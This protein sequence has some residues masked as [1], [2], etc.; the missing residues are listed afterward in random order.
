MATYTGT[1]GNDSWTVVNPGTFSL[2]GLGGVDV[3]NLGTSLRS[4]YTITKASDG[5]VHIDSISSASGALHATL[6]NM[7]TLTFN[8][9]RDV[10]DLTTYFGDSIPPVLNSVSPLA[11]SSTVA[12]DA[13]LVFTFSEAIARG[14]GTVTLAKAD[15][16]VVATYNAADS[17]NL[18]IAGTALTINPTAD[19]DFGSSYKV[20]I[21]AGSIKD[22]AGNNYA[23]ESTYAFTTANGLVIAGTAGDDVLLGSKGSDTINAGAGNDSITGGPG[24]D[25]ID[26]GSG[27]NTAVYSGNLANY[28]LSHS[29][30]TYTVRDKTGA[31]GT[32][33]VTNVAAL[34]FADMTV[35]LQVQAKVA[36]APAADV[37]HIIELYVAFFNRTPDADGLSYWLEQKNAG[38][39]INQIA[40]AF[41]NAGVQFSSQTGFSTSMSNAD[42]VN[43]VY[44]NVLGRTG[45]ADAGGLAYWTAKLVDGSA[46]HGSLVSAILDSAHSF[47]GDATWGWVANLLDNKLLV[48]KTVA[49]DWGINFNTS[50]DSITHGMAIA[51]AVTP[52]D[53][54]AALAL[55]G[56]APADMSLG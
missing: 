12:V 37:Q 22:L 55:I 9:G 39:S 21:S 2:D 5:S 26:G 10:L 25:V 16:T 38:Q 19:L 23:G 41:Y 49:V 29:G 33:T 34:K 32:D 44:I 27:T 15:G 20:S 51:A 50:A 56:I 53:T 14:A 36:A 43:K 13:N 24:N 8:S 42:F 52:S 47:K 4:A 35:N 11:L 1:A 7:E 40:D 46:T 6:Y 28:A 30:A 18:T 17:A 54:A 31:D 48:G 3:L 45:G